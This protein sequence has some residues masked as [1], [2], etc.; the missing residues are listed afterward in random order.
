MFRL[1]RLVMTSTSPPGE[2][3]AKRFLRV[4]SNPGDAVDGIYPDTHQSTHI[5]HGIGV[6]MCSL[7]P[8]IH[9][10]TQIY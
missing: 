8:P 3:T 7:I 2:G 6:L 4:F 10:T 9:S 1:K 5:K